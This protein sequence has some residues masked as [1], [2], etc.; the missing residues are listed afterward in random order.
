MQFTPKLIAMTA[1]ALMATSAFALTAEEHKAEQQRITAEY[2]AAKAQCTSLTANAK[3]VCEKEAE[4][5]EKVAKAELEHRKDPT[6]KRRY[7]VAKTKADTA[8]AVAK[9]KCDDLKGNAEDVCEKDAKAQHVKA[10]EAAKVADARADGSKDGNAK[11]AHVSE[12]RKEAAQ[13]V[14][15]ADYKAAMERCDA[16]SGDV[17]DKCQNDAKRTFGQ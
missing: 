13:N 15:E 14:R 2:K 11:A 6:E 9:E 3:D 4:G 17:K 10:L 5:R 16:L 1:A 12:V 7:N 8:Y